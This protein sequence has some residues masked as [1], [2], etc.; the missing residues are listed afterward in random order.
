MWKVLGING[1]VHNDAVISI[2]IL[3]MMMIAMPINSVAGDNNYWN[4]LYTGRGW[5]GTG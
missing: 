4:Y 3:L 1:D 5:E 2:M